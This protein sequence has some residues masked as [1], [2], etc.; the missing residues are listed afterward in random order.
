MKKSF[1]EL[2]VPF[3]AVITAA[4]II[5]VNN[6]LF[7]SSLFTHIDL[8][9]V[10][11]VGV[12]LA[13]Y[14]ALTC[15]VSLF[16]L[17]FSHRFLFKPLLILMLV[18]TAIISYFQTEYG[19]IINKSMLQNVM[20]T[21]SREAIELVT[22]PLI[23]HVTLKGVIPALLITFIP[24]HYKSF[25]RQCLMSGFYALLLVTITGLAVWSSYKDLALINRE[26]QE[27]RFYINPT[28]PI[29]SV[30]KYVYAKEGSELTTPV[31][32]GADAHQV[33]KGT[34][35]TVTVL[36]I[37]ETARASNFS[38]NGYSRKTN[39]Y[40]EKERVI[41][42]TNAWSC[43]TSTA[44]SVPCIFSHLGRDQY[45]VEKARQYTN[46][47][48]VLAKA[49]IAV[50]WRDN[51][52]GCKGVC[53]RVVTDD[54]SHA[55]HS[56]LCNEE[57]CFDEILLSD[58]EKFIDSQTADTLIILH[59]KGSHGPA[60]YKRYPKEFRIFTPECTSS[61]PQE[62]S[63]EELLNA[64]D[65]TI[66][67]TDFFLDRIIQFLKK[68]QKKYNSLMLYVSDHGESLGENGLYLH[69]L[70]WFLAPDD[71]KHI[72]FIVWLSGEFE[73]EEGID[74]QCLSEHRNKRYSHDSVFHTVLGIFNVEVSSVYKPELD[75]LHG[76]QIPSGKVTA[77]VD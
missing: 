10:H 2:S 8:S 17:V 48:D 14:I 66:A 59:Q 6:H 76:C 1:P 5:L 44:E 22:F 52:S 64:Y 30:F 71:Q 70:P 21:D 77:A 31:E 4:Y 72:P 49:G 42:F 57:E 23:W 61:S 27:L 32:I 33:K 63:R 45:S 62:C 58:L 11:Y 68:N 56:E 46:L 16:F 51:N 75:L 74:F 38:L 36:V 60:Y 35:K 34:G 9:S 7:W 37:G 3:V 40:L 39:P 55:T 53:K 19:V 13:L 20:E 26:H 12:V 25:L 65:N 73:K 29:Y 24:V 15:I 54:L 43:G 28:Y 18:L 47:L 67:Y 69:G 50:L 41:S